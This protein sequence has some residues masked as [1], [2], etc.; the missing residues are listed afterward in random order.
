MALFGGAYLSPVTFYSDS[1]RKGD[2]NEPAFWEKERSSFGEIAAEF[3]HT[4]SWWRPGERH[5]RSNALLCTSR[6]F[7]TK[8]GLIATEVPDTSETD[9]QALIA[10]STHLNSFLG[11]LNLGGI[12]HSPISGKQICHVEQKAD[13]LQQISGEGDQYSQ[14]S[15]ERALQRYQTPYYPRTPMIQFDWVS[16]R[17][18]RLHELQ[19]AYQLGQS[20]FTTL[21]VDT[22]LE[23]LAL[24]AYASYTLHKWSD[25]LLLGWAF[26]ENLIELQWKKSI[27]AN[28]SGERKKSLEDHRTYTA[29]VKI[30]MLH[31]VGVI[32]EALHS[33]LTELRKSRNDLM[34]N[35]S[36]PSQQDVSDL[37]DVTISLIRILTSYEARF[38]NPGWSWS[39][40]WMQD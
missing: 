23:I 18:Y 3:D 6:I 40:G 20:I 36:F 31:L 2:F 9:E 13:H 34:H 12:F 5:S 21:N 29:A 37:F 22:G 33:R 16:L 27:L 26:I 28:A 32:D 10:L 15:L 7:I 24:E 38:F 8:D 39:G 25:S 14:V 11:L 1:Y 17:I 19:Q 35:G 30:E 4:S